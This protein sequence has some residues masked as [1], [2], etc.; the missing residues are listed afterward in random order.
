LSGLRLDG[1]EQMQRIEM[2]GRGFE[3]AGIKL[4]GVTQ[5]ALAM[6]ADR[7]I[8]GLRDIERR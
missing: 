7:L 2:I 6:Q 1:A 3:D 5:A 4:F 8:H